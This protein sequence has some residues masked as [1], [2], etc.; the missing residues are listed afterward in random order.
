MATTCCAPNPKVRGHDN[1]S[2]GRTTAPGAGVRPSPCT[3]QRT[4]KPINR[5]LSPEG[6]KPI[7][8][9]LIR[10][11]PQ[12]W[13]HTSRRPTHTGRA[14]EPLALIRT[15]AATRRQRITPPDHAAANPEYDRIG[16]A[17]PAQA[18]E[19]PCGAAIFDRRRG[20]RGQSSPIGCGGGRFTATASYPR[21]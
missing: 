4:P 1:R 18:P 19:I 12:L 17:F 10:A 9:I 11:N 21:P 16:L 2:S 3:V 7:A 8:A 14:M 6:P 20:G 5:P 15:T 13:R